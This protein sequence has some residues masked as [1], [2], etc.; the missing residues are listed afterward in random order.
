LRKTESLPIYQTLASLWIDYWSYFIGDKPP[1]WLWRWTELKKFLYS[2][3]RF[4]ELKLDSPM[5]D[6]WFA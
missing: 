2:R 1:L 6:V 4:D 5:S 3:I